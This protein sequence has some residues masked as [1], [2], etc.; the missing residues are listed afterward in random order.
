M[1]SVPAKSSSPVA[2]DARL[3]E[4]KQRALIEAVFSSAKAQAESQAVSSSAKVQA[5][6]QEVS[7]SVNSGS[8]RKEEYQGLLDKITDTK[9]NRKVVEKQ[10]LKAAIRLNNVPSSLIIN[11]VKSGQTALALN[12]VKARPSEHDWEEAKKK[13]NMLDAVKMK[14]ELLKVKL[15][16][17]KKK[18]KD[19]TEGPLKSCKDVDTLKAYN[20]TLPE[21]CAKPLV[22]MSSESLTDIS[23]GAPNEVLSEDLA[24]APAEA[25]TRLPKKA[26]KDKAIESVKKIN[27][28]GDIIITKVSAKTAEAKLA[29]EKTSVMKAEPDFLNREMEEKAEQLEPMKKREQ[30]L[31]LKLA[32]LKQK[33]AMKKK[34]KVAIKKEPIDDIVVVKLEPEVR[35][36]EEPVK[37]NMD[38]LGMEKKRSNDL[39]EEVENMIEMKRI[40]MNKEK[41]K[42]IDKQR[43][44]QQEK[45][46]VEKKKIEE[47]RFK[48][49]LAENKNA[50]E[51]QRIQKALEEKKKAEGE[52]LSQKAKEEEENNRKTQEEEEKVKKAK[53]EE[54]KDQKAKEDK[55]RVRKAIQFIK[56][57]EEKKRLEEKLLAETR[58]NR[59]VEEK[60]LEKA[61]EVACIRAR[62]EE[63]LRKS[64]EE[65][66]KAEEEARKMAIEEAKKK[67]VEEAEKS[68]KE[69]EGRKKALEEA[70]RKGLEAKQAREQE[71]RRKKL[72]LRKAREEAVRGVR[73]EMEVRKKIEENRKREE[74][75]IAAKE[76]QS[77]ELLENIRQEVNKVALETGEGGEEV[78]LKKKSR[79]EIRRHLK[80]NYL[81]V[82]Y[83]Y[84]YLTDRPG[85]AGSV[86]H[87]AI[88]AK[89]II[90]K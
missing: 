45:K 90:I 59:E 60:I 61:R 35:I 13:A 3:A 20:E 25:A 77:A 11:R 53:E 29:K 30:E 47:L 2:Q 4:A 65:Q 67:A 63:V 23:A 50:D 48:K 55:E 80:V 76:Q 15:L 10:P 78:R 28:P 51:K 71:E 83:L 89:L 17:L 52:A 34:N 18:I 86:L 87:T 8:S 43:G 81:L 70:R 73:R 56:E 12:G 57:K 1:K 6:S 84:V 27:M 82:R 9:L 5:E 74:E 64:R 37:G 75:E 85:V 32:L 44:T 68:A 49:A 88:L 62:E 72:M 58:A 40:E 54:E 16:E 46:R 38:I 31:I 79:K 33:V 66:K 21:A 39:E 7:S 19:R 42:V 41:K 26:Y 69:I 36:K 24:E 22:E 14:E